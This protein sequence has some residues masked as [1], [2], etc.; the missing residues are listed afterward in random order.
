MKD[1]ALHLED[2]VG[3][4]NEKFRKR[5]PANHIAWINLVMIN[6]MYCFSVRAAWQICTGKLER[7]NVVY[8]KTN[9]K[10]NNDLQ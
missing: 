3:E 10:I 6:L 9:G 5:V 2:Q 4:V 8:W 7:D 1:H